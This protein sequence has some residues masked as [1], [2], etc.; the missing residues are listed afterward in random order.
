MVQNL[1]FKM[2]DNEKSRIPHGPRNGFKVSDW[3]VLSYSDAKP[4]KALT[5]ESVP[6]TASSKTGSTTPGEKTNLAEKHPGA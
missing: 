3:K 4:I 2:Q 5:Y 6:V 1:P